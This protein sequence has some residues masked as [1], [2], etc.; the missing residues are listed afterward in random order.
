MRDNLGTSASIVTGAGVFF[1]AQAE[2]VLDS[3]PL[4]D[5]GHRN[6]DPRGDP[7]LA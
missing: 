3:T 6:D 1:C 2:R 4:Y 7:R 5:A